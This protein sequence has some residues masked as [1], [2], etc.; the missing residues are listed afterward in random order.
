VGG[1]G[2]A[3]LFYVLRDGDKGYVT[4]Q[5]WRRHLAAMLDTHPGL[6][7]LKATP[8]FQVLY[9]Y[10]FQVIYICI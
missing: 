10:I 1:S 6:E 4:R 2:G 9:I 3:R 8:E 5:D 7:F